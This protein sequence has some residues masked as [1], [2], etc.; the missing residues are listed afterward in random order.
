MTL[1]ERTRLATACGLDRSANEIMCLP[2][3]KSTTQVNSAHSY[4]KS[5]RNTNSPPP[6]LHVLKPGPVAAACEEN[7]PTMPKLYAMV[8][9]WYRATVM[10]RWTQPRPQPPD[11]SLDPVAGVASRPCVHTHARHTRLAGRGSWTSSASRKHVIQPG[12]ST[13]SLCARLFPYYLGTILPLEGNH[14]TQP[15]FA[16]L[17]RP[18]HSV[19]YAL[20]TWQPSLVS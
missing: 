6:W 11:P 3:A 19:F 8:P 12:D 18:E 20:R 9:E 7:S 14:P 13:S 16:L 4:T 15:S 5:Q 10:R 1:S 17:P 2:N